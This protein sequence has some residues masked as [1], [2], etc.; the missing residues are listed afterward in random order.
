MRR[1]RIPASPWQHF[2]YILTFVTS[3]QLK[4]W[5]EERGCTF[6]PAKGPSGNN[7][8]NR[9]LTVAAQ[10]RMRSRDR[11]GAVCA[12]CHGYLRTIPKGSH[13]NVRLGLK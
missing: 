9:S 4:R 6:A 5:L 10:N 13:L 2:C 11:Q 3:N 1:C 7:C 8:F 12:A